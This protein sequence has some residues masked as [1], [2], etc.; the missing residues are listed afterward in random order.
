[1]ERQIQRM[2]AIDAFRFGKH[3]HFDVVPFSFLASGFDIEYAPLVFQKLLLI[4]GVP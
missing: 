2:K 1:M 4:V 3:L